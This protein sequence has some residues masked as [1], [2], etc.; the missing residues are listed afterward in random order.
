M[1]EGLLP[2]ACD[3]AA[4]KLLFVFAEWHGLAKLRVHTE[5]TL[6]ILK[7]VTTELGVL[8]REFATL[9]QDMNVQETPVEYARRRKQYEA[10]KA[11][12][13]VRSTQA[14]NAS[15]P[16]G[17]GDGRRKCVLN[18]N[19]YKMHALGDYVRTIER[20][21]TTDSYSTQIVCS[22]LFDISGIR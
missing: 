15:T 6:T 21:G 5:T 9:T 19:T 18:L 17:V 7:A 1:F 16:S 8:M 22:R 13:M 20:Y 3:D 4:C 11:A 12:S 14:T 2:K 10:R